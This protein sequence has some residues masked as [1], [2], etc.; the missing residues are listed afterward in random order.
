MLLSSVTEKLSVGVIHRYQL[1]LSSEPSEDSEVVLSITNLAS[2]VKNLDLFNGS[3]GFSANCSPADPERPTLPLTDLTPEL[4]FSPSVFCG[5]TWSTKLPHKMTNFVI[6]L[7][8]ELITSESFIPY[9]IEVFSK[10]KSDHKE[11]PLEVSLKSVD[12]NEIWGTLKFDEEVEKTVHLVI[13][14]HG[15][16][17]SQLDLLHMKEE[18]ERDNFSSSDT[19]VVVVVCDVNHR[20]TTDG[21]Y[22]GGLRIANNILEEVEWENR[23]G[24]SASTSNMSYKVSFIG[25]SLGGVY[26]LCSIGI[27]EQKTD[28]RFFDVFKPC[29]FITLASPLLGSIEHPWVA[30]QFCAIGGMGQSGRDLMLV[31]H[32]EEIPGF[33]D[34]A[35]SSKSILV[36]ISHPGSPSYQALS[37]FQDRTAY[38]N[39]ANDISV[40]FLTSSL[41]SKFDVSKYTGGLLRKLFSKPIPQETIVHV[42]EIEL[43]EESKV[44]DFLNLQQLPDLAQGI[45]IDLQTNLHWKKVLVYMSKLTAHTDIIVRRW[46]R[47]SD[48]SKVIQHLLKH[49]PF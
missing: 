13:L 48:G 11:A 4:Q 36:N 47:N 10:T 34:V 40:G 9:K 15:L 18:I 7:A 39:I 17:G 37:K 5:A 23:F 21:V 1:I 20:L 19:R 14:N 45:A 38:S 43:N 24:N 42:E 25:H 41:A 26:N 3:Y 6:D 22:T 2:V 33:T 28:G 16:M 44:E 49:H 32:N 27:L 30:N 31:D 35:T 29:H 46:P 8:S 12:T